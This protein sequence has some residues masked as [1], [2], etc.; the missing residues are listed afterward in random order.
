MRGFCYWESSFI[1]VSFLVFFNKD[2]LSSNQKK[3]K[4]IKRAEPRGRQL[5]NLRRR[6]QSLE[7]PSEPPW[8]GDIHL[9]SPLIKTIGDIHLSLP[10]NSNQT[11]IVQFMFQHMNLRPNIQ[12]DKSVGLE[13]NKIRSYR[14]LSTSFYL[15]NI[16][17]IQGLDPKLRK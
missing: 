3:K 5:R 13:P 12:D 7:N 2:S 10:L 4:N 15:F 9:S 11:H 6:C 16:R 8:H 17:F 14:S 1:L